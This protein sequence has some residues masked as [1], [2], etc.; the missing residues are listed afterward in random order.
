MILTIFA[1]EIII[2]VAYND[3]LAA[4]IDHK[5]LVDRAE[6]DGISWSWIHTYYANMGGF[7][8]EKKNG[9]WAR[10]EYNMH[11][12]SG[13]DILILRQLRYIEKLPNISKTEP[14]AIH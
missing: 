11:H 14:K 3:R 10:S 12:M 4:R 1:P 13:R 6:E 9:H 5:S 2:A 7:V 8:V